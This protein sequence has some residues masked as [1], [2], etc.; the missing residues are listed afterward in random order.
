MKITQ[1]TLYE[2]I[3]EIEDAYSNKKL[4]KSQLTHEKISI[5]G[6]LNK[7]ILNKIT[8]EAMELEVTLEDYYSSIFAI[9]DSYEA[10]E[11]L[12]AAKKGKTKKLDNTKREE[13]ED[14]SAPI[15]AVADFLLK[16]KLSR[17]PLVDSDA[18]GYRKQKIQ[19]LSQL[20]SFDLCKEKV[21]EQ[22][23][24]IDQKIKL[25]RDEKLN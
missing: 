4:I 15:E 17:V 19:S 8:G 16:N 21:L 1:E 3:R 11:F 23:K 7:E 22:A 20:I 13:Y 24:Y 6:T 9:I 25:Y 18:K 2:K 14:S 12:I 10:N 5:K